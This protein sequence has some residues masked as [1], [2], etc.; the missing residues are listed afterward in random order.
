MSSQ[1]ALFDEI[2]TLIH[3]NDIV[4]FM[5]GTPD[6][7]Q[8]GFSGVVCQILERLEVPFMGINILARQDLRQAIKDYTQWP[9][10]PQLYIKGS[11]IGGADIVRDM[12]QTGELKTLLVDEGLLGA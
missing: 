11:F 2:K 10:I 9:T 1:D 4:L 6:M 12:Y 3:N 5:K 8:C 7:P